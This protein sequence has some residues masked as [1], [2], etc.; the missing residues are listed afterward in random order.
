MQIEIEYE[1]SWRNSFLDGS[2]D[3]PLPKKGRKYVASITSLKTEGNYLK[4]DVSHNT[5]MGILNRLIGDQQKLYM[6]RKNNNYY[7]KEI[8]SKIIFEDKPNFNNEIIFLRNISVS[9]DQNS[10]TGMIKTNDPMF[11][12]EYSKEFWGVLAL[13]FDELISFIINDEVINQNIELDPISI[14]DRFDLLS[15]IK[16]VDETEKIKKALLILD[17]MFPDTNY[18]NNKNKVVPSTLYCSCL[19]VQQK[20]LSSKYD[21]NSVLTKSGTI[22]GISKRIFTDLLLVKRRRYLETPI[23]KKSL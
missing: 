8:E 23:S 13:D 14:S 7:F 21:M 1:A 5:I 9:T 16:P 18:C 11:T 3:E 20:R 17:E 19:Y 15:K 12:S 2:N 22:S 6:A 10:F 4:R